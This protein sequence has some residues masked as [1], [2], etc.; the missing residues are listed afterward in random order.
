MK[1]DDFR[2]LLLKKK[3]SVAIVHSSLREKEI[4]IDLRELN[5]NKEVKSTSSKKS[6]ERSNFVLN[7]A[8]HYREETT[9]FWGIPNGEQQQKSISIN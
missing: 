8:K 5:D 1:Y 7:F 9:F 4:L 6:N 3:V 2:I